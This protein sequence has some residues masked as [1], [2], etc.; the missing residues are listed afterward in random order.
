MKTGQQFTFLGLFL[1]L[2]LKSY[3]SLKDFD[4]PALV[5][6]FPSIFLIHRRT[7]HIYSRTDDIL[8]NPDSLIAPDSSVFAFS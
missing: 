4:L 7:Y 5:D 2:Y 3:C 8:P 6:T 1:D